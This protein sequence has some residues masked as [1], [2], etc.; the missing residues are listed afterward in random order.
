M[1]RTSENLLRFDSRSIYSE[2]TTCDIIVLDAKGMKAG[3][4]KTKWQHQNGENSCL[5]L[6]LF[7]IQIAKT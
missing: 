4:N 3:K 7:F 5:P 6:G 1:T 2:P